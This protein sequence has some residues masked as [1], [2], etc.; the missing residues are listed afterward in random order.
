M[1]DTNTLCGHNAEILYVK[2]DGAYSNQSVLTRT[3]GR[4]D[5]AETY[6]HPRLLQRQKKISVA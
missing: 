5:V 1:K 3:C 6:R 4:L 2:A